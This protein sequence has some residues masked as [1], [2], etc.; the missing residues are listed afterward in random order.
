MT[1][2]S[3]IQEIK[4]QQTFCIIKPDGVKRNLTGQILSRLENTG[5][6][7]VALNM[8]LA[9][10]EQIKK[11]YPVNDSAWVERIGDKGLST[12]DSLGLDPIEFLGTNNK[13][14]IGEKVV[15]SLIDYMTSGPIICL[16]VEGIQVVEV[17]R[18]LAGHT[19]PFKAETGTI[20]GDFSADSPAIA[21]VEGRAIH[22][23]FHASET[24]DEAKKEIELWFGTN[25]VD[26]KLAGEEILYNKFY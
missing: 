10:Q 20:R 5:L 3:K 7:I 11:H 2:N 23:L 13:K 4:K 26:Y 9:T 14:E 15:E 8:Q 16:V 25:L 1:G 24:V 22:N 12:F 18:K 6:K 19:L 17:V 21:N